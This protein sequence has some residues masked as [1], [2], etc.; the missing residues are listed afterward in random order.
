MCDS[1]HMCPASRATNTFLVRDEDSINICW[2][3][4][5]RGPPGDRVTIVPL[6]LGVEE[7]T[8]LASQ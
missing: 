3:L 8:Q 4:K 2:G 1:R 5:T 6:F 7:T